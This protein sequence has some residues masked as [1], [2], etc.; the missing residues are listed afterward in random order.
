MIIRIVID[1]RL[2]YLL[3]MILIVMETLDI[4]MLKKNM[5]NIKMIIKINF[6]YYQVYY[7]LKMIMK[8]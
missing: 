6:V 2:I 1:L 3:L 4:L 8:K 5:I 7:L